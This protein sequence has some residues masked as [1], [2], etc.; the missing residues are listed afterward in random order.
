MQT[1]N[2]YRNRAGPLAV[3]DI[4]G[5][6]TLVARADIPAGTV[7]QYFRGDKTWQ[8]LDKSAVGLSNVDNTSDVSKP[9]STATQAALDGKAPIAHTHVIADVTNL[10]T[11][12]DGK[13]PLD[14]QLTSLAG[15]A[16]TGNAGKVVKVNVGE[17]G[18]ELSADLT[19]GGGGVTSFNTRTGDVTLTSGDVTGALTFTPISQADGDARYALIAHS[20]AI[21][22]VTGL[23]TALDGK[24]SLAGGTLTGALGG[25]TATFSTNATATTLRATGNT[26]TGFSGPGVEVGWTG[27][28]GRVLAFDRSTSTRLPFQID[29]ASVDIRPAGSVVATFSTTGLSITGALSAT[30]NGA[31]GNDTVAATATPINL[32]LG[33]T[34]S[35]A[36]G[37]NLKLKLFN[38][39]GSL[40]G[41][42]VSA[43]QIDYV[44]PSSAN[45]AFWL[46]TNKFVSISTAGISVTGTGTFTGDVT[47]PD[48]AY[49]A[50]WDG[51]LE[52]PTKNA[53]YDKI[54]TLG[55][56]GA[57]PWART[58]LTTDYNNATITFA[59]ITDG[60]RTFTYTPP[61][62]SNFTLE[63]DII[64]WT[65]TAAN[66]PRIGVNVGAGANAGY[67]SV[68]IQQQGATATTVVQ[69]GGGY[70]NP[71][72]AVNVQMAV[73]GL[74]AANTPYWCWVSIKGKSGSAPTPIS[75]Q[76]ACETAAASTC[77]V[78]AG[79]EMRT[80]SG[81]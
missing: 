3:E 68:I 78:K 1:D 33:G 43:S 21:A 29:A 35:S 25:T 58:T 8:T 76:M 80:R 15:L 67:G 71:G 13:Q 47:V 40:Y 81:Y 16:Y 5:L 41:F 4:V 51:S 30:G 20:H 26:F 74:P 63:V 10:Q 23:Q 31:L 49:G 28:Q 22:D 46:G 77:Y 27:T 61:S 55:G 52:V 57:D 39:G 72:A 65:A 59:N 6:E 50:G 34:Y 48:E 56:G 32:D 60:T 64:L 54:Q 69:A 17:T 14:D 9:I 66:L 18:F 24:L 12:L 11:S 79:S 19:G 37:L 62:N 7:D 42:G 73:G 70:N 38:G 36:A 75:I 53:L 44:A 45:H 2:R